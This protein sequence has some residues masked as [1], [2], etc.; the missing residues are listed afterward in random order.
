M[1]LFRFRK[2]TPTEPDR[3]N[4]DAESQQPPDDAEP[5]LDDP[6][7]AAYY[8]P[9]NIE[10]AAAWRTRALLVAI[11]CLSATCIFLVGVI[12]L[13]LPL[14]RS[15]PYLVTFHDR[16]EQI[17]ALQPIAWSTTTADL[18][19]ESEVRR[20]ILERTQMVPIAGEMNLRWFTPD[21]FVPAHTSPEAYE[22]FQREAQKLWEDNVREPFTRT[23]TIRS[24]VRRD[25]T[26]WRTEYSTRDDYA[27]PSIQDPPP[28]HWTAI[29]QTAPLRYTKPPT[30][31]QLLRNPTG[32]LITQWNQQ[33]ILSTD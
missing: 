7:V 32:L 6:F 17:V 18:V 30:R 11:C 5:V 9:D 15:V 24:L 1:A 22:A 12:L 10:R 29:I 20:Y 16:G 14:Q 3:Q 8:T 4:P 21:G 33:P 2:K 27:D 19:L 25:P 28:L 13:M 23:T 31:R 26:L